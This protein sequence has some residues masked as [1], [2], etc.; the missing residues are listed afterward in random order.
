MSIGRGDGGAHIG[1]LGKHRLD[2]GA[3]LVNV[4]FQRKQ[5]TLGAELHL[6]LAAQ[7]A[8][9]ENLGIVAAV[10]GQVL[11]LLKH[12]ARGGVVGKVDVG[13]FGHNLKELHLVPVA[14]DARPGAHHAE[15][16]GF[17]DNGIAFQVHIAGAG[18]AFRG[19]LA[20][21]FS[22]RGFLIGGRAAFRFAAAFA[23]AAV[24]GR[25]YGNQHEHGQ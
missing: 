20:A 14:V 10:K 16:N 4:L 8:A 25:K 11:L 6:L 19:L 7:L 2:V 21:A 12:F 23:A 24:A 13:H 15:G 17:V 3:V 5:N 22:L 9:E 1:L 18:L